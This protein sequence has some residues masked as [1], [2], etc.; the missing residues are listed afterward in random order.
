[1]KRILLYMIVLFGWSQGEAQTNMMVS[2][3]L[4]E[5]MMLGNYD[6]AVY[7]A[8]PVIDLPADVS[9][10]ILNRVSADTLLRYLDQLRTFHNR[11]SGSDTLSATQG[12][13]AALGWAYQ[14]FEQYS[15]Q[16]NNRLTVSYLR[17][18]A[19]I[20]G[21]TAHKNVFAVLPGT[22]TSLKDIVLVEA[23]IDSRCNDEC[24][25]NCVA[26]G[27]EDNG[28]GS[29]LVLELARV[30]SKYSFKRT[31]VFMLTTAEEQ[32]LQGATAFAGYAA[33]KG[34]KIR[35][36]F[37]NDV[38]GGII[39]GNTASQPGCSGVGT[40]DSTHV[41][42]F[43]YGAFNSAHKGLAR[44]VK[45]QYE[46]RVKAQ[47]V[48]PMEIHIMTPEDRTGRGGDHIPFRQKNIAAVRF[49]SANENGDAS[50]GAGYADR[51]HTSDDILG[52]DTNGDSVLDSFFVDFNY[53]SRNVVING[54]G[55]AMA[56]MGPIIPTFSFGGGNN[57]LTVTVLTQTSYQH[58][59]VGLRTLTNDW[60]TVIS[61]T[62]TSVTIPVIPANYIASVASVDERGVESLFSG[63]QIVR[64]TG[65]EEVAAH[66][67]GITLM[68]NTPNPADEATTISVMLQKGIQYKTAY[69]IIRDL[70]G[71]TVESIP[72]TLS[73]GMNEV[74]Y[75][76]G[77]HHTG[78][79]IYTL[80]IDGKI[81]DSKRMVF[82]N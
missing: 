40:I 51:Q 62:G 61:F 56:A 53:L 64:L 11:S 38:I 30:M 1:M 58:F 34:I 7:A 81:V 43:S 32:G 2:N 37:N 6:P 60:D 77:Y 20:C 67:A 29:T 42:L 79:F 73:P 75:R 13:G 55:L 52:V 25:I 14:K 33:Q 50:L 78:V 39:C 19:A 68:Q 10:G 47:S 76:H 18:N 22:D 8:N 24:D 27:M 17:F 21:V 3:P 36:V 80:E 12:I 5:Q 63:E 66:G 15:S 72:I 4:V 54:T 31:I 23:H 46:N 65:I 16:N 69:I 48:V 82:V 70:K 35:A 44:F 71:Q 49:T 9:E 57:K 59:K 74:D 41:R 28:S 26:E 45:L